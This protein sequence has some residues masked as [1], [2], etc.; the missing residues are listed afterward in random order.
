MHGEY[1]A[2]SD[3]EIER[4]SGKTHLI[5]NMKKVPE[6]AP[7][8]SN[9]PGLPAKDGG[10]ATTSPDSMHQNN[11]HPT[12]IEDMRAFDG[13]HAWDPSV[14]H[15]FDSTLPANIEHLG[16]NPTTPIFPST[17]DL[18][19]QGFGLI[20][21]TEDPGD[22]NLN[23]N[24]GMPTLQSQTAPAPVGSSYPAAEN[25]PRVPTDDVWFRFMSELGLPSM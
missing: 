5:H 13:A 20:S 14:D 24:I 1:S 23:F 6:G 25:P 18:S 3:T 22:F 21:Q 12:I 4:W 15:L 11:L 7:S 9:S 10:R 2:I 17:S 16:W 19:L 8:S